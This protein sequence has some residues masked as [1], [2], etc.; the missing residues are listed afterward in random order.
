[1][2]TVFGIA[3]PLVRK[4]PSRLLWELLD[5]RTGLPMHGVPW[6][7]VF[8]A[9]RGLLGSPG[10]TTRMRVLDDAERDKVA[11]LEL[12]LLEEP[13]LPSELALLNERGLNPH[14]KAP[15]LVTSDAPWHRARARSTLAR[16]SLLED[17]AGR[18]HG[19]LH[20]P[21]RSVV[22]SAAE[23]SSSEPF[24]GPPGIAGRGPRKVRF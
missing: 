2:T 12:C 3:E 9:P 18:A 22:R 20:P 7:W 23:P 19:G 13:L 16:S 1:M 15:F 10:L 24:A 5:R 11:A 4:E 21:R 17:S 8:D 6:V 14:G